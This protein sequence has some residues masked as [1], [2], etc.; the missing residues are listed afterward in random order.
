MCN[1][2]HFNAC[3]IHTFKP[4]VTYF[5]VSNLYTNVLDEY[6]MHIQYMYFFAFVMLLYA[7]VVTI[8]KACAKRY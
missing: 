1:S 5:N 6:K 2:N 3:S 7:C 4:L 8:R